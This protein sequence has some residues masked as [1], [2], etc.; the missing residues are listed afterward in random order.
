MSAAN[1]F[2][3]VGHRGGLVVGFDGSDPAWEAVRWA[4]DE[5]AHRFCPLLL[6]HAHLTSVT[7]AWG[8]VAAPGWG[9]AAVFDDTSLVRQA[10]ENVAVAAEECRRLEPGLEVDVKVV[11]GRATPALIE[12]ARTVDAELLVVGMSHQWALPRALIGSTVTSLVHDVD[13]PVVA[14]RGGQVGRSGPVIVGVDDSPDSMPAVRFAAGYA[15]RHACELRP[16]RDDAKTLL[17][18]S[19]DAQLLVVSD[20]GDNAVHRAL[21]GSVSHTA[22]NHASCPVA[23]VPMPC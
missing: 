15:K 16:V 1:P 5:A 18:Q 3:E 13:R 12:A 4:A 7:S 20:R 6:V 11:G 10:E 9:P 2:V 21:F 14:V 17:E 22:L 19:E 23:V 8:A